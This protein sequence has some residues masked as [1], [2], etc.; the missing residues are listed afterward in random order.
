MQYRRM[1]SERVRAFAATLANGRSVAHMAMGNST[2]VRTV[3]GTPR[4]GAQLARLTERVTDEQVAANKDWMLAAT[5]YA[6][7]YTG[8]FDF[9]LDMKSKV[10][11]GLTISQMRGVLNCMRAEAIHIVNARQVAAPVAASPVAEK[12][13]NDVQDGFYTV[14]F[15]DGSHVTIRI[16][17]VSEKQ[18]RDGRAHRYAS[19]LCGPINMSDYRRFA[20]V[21]PNGFRVFKSDNFRKQ[22]AALEILMSAD[23]NGQTAYGK[24]YAKQ[25]TRCY[26]C[27]KLLT[28]P[29]SIESGIGPICAG[30][31]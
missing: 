5:E 29:E 9:M 21:N 27:G 28:E 14:K 24:A 13:L 20:V 1:T 19:Y 26:R 2:V 25:S 4:I 10:A 17:R 16:N 15:E 8:D 31:E 11:D 6:K 30:R 12:M 7:N 18:S 23:A 22:A 3:T